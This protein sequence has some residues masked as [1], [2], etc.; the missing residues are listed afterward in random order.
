VFGSWRAV[1]QHLLNA[2]MVVTTPGARISWPPTPR[3]DAATVHNGRQWHTI[4]RAQRVH[5]QK[6]RNAETPRRIRLQHIDRLRLEH[7]AEVKQVVAVEDL[8]GMGY[9]V[10]EADSGRAGLAILERDDLCDLMII[11][12]VM[13]GLSG[14]DT[15]RLARRTRP[16]F[17]VLFCSGFADLSRFEG[18]VGNEVVLKKPFRPDILAE[19]VRAMLGRVWPIDASKIVPLRRSE[20]S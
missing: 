6:S 20:P 15:A 9:I 2:D 4:C 8:R 17:K 3:A 12:M 16:D 19:G 18:E 10:T 14:V 13:T 5:L 11:D 1:E 7:A